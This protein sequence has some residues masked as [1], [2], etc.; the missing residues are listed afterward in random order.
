[1]T[2][3]PES[4]MFSSRRSEGAANDEDVRRRRECAKIAKS[5]YRVRRARTHTFGAHA[6]LFGEP[7]WDILL[8]LYIAH[9]SGRAISRTKASKS[10]DVPQ[11]TG[12]RILTM[13]AERGLVTRI[14]DPG[15][16]RRSFVGLSDA[17][18]TLMETCMMAFLDAAGRAPRPTQKRRSR[19]KTDNPAA[20]AEGP[21]TVSAHDRVARPPTKGAIVREP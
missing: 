5:L 8:N 20:R 3:A 19:A 9:S 14:D 17:A 10:G 4:E 2:D 18:I 7:A 16:R 1:M 12:L 21:T 15:D 6:A 13:L 11:T